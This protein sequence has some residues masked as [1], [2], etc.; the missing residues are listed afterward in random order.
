M[1]P[2]LFLS[3]GAPTLALSQGPAAAF[4]K[5]LPGLL[6]ERPKAILVISAHWETAEPRLTSA[7]Q[8][9]TIHDFGGFGPILHAM[10]YDAPGAPQVATRAKALLAG[11]GL[12][13]ELDPNR[14]LDHGAWVPLILA[15][16]DGDIPVVQLSVQ[17]AR[18]PDYHLRLGRALAP[19]R[20]EGVLIIGSGS[21]TH[22]LSSF[23]GQPEDAPEPGWVLDFADWTDAALMQGRLDDLLNYRTLAPH[24]RRNHPTEEHFLPLLTAVGAG[25]GVSARR[26]HRSTTYGVLHMDAYAFGDVT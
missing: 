5:T 24:A 22:D 26:L 23:R 14:G 15:W 10:R 16:P 13:A 11:V 25:G 17:T 6:P 2:T 9:T 21:W 8:N 4:L 12:N 20:N 19:L 7:E 3:H 1:L 18:G